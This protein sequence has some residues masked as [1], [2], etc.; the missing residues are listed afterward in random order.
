MI[1]VIKGAVNGLYQDDI[2]RA[3]TAGS[4]AVVPGT[5]LKLVSSKWVIAGTGDV[6]S[7][8]EAGPLLYIAL[9]GSTDM[10]G[11]FAGNQQGQTASADEEPLVTAVPLHGSNYTVETDMIADTELADQTPLTVGANGKFVVKASD[12]QTCYGFVIGASRS[13]WDGTKVAVQNFRTGGRTTVAAV[14][15]AYIPV[16]AIA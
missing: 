6:G 2:T 9:T 16:L 1:N 4:A 12:A 8:T 3:L 13:H 15:L 5:L 7:A 11:R 14:R 10:T